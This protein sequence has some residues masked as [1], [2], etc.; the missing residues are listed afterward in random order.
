MS[1]VSLEPWLD[2]RGLAGHLC[3]SVRQ[4]E[5]YMAAGAPHATLGRG[6]RFR[7]SEVQMWLEET[8]RL[9]LSSPNQQEEQHG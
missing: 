4:V 9:R 1:A 2:K 8:G 3:C 5:R 6:V 7:I